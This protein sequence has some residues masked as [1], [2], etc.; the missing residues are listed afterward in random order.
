MAK[1]T[2][3]AAL[4]VQAGGCYFG[5]YGVE[6]WDE[7]RDARLYLGPHPVVAHPPCERWGAYATGGPAALGRF[8]VGDDGG[9]FA[10]AL[11]AVRRYGGVLEH[12]AN[13]KA[14]SAHGLAKP[15]RAGGWVRADDLGGMTCCVEQGAYGH[16]AR[17]ATWLYAVGTNLPELRWGRAPGDFTRATPD[18][19]PE[20]RRRELRTG[21]CQRL[22]KRQRAAT[23]LEFRNVLLAMA[24]SVSAEAISAPPA[25][26]T[27]A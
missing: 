14:W 20:E 17:K 11:S 1:H 16:R 26:H 22:S 21:A 25:E 6:P 2:K 23:P 5:L 7:A 24:I 4:Y 15:P 19:S 9:C 12:P 18:M 8:E 10:A 3:V 13:S 27:T